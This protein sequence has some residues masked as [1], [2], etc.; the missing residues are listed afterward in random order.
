MKMR[1]LA[2]LCLIVGTTISSGRAQATRDAAP[3]DSFARAER[4]R[5]VDLKKISHKY[6]PCLRNEN[7]GVVEAAI[8]V[9]TRMKLYSPQTNLDELREEIM[10]LAA[11]GRNASIRY[12]AYI[13][14]MVIANPLWFSAEATREYPHD[15]EM[16]SAL[17]GR[18]ARVMLNPAERPIAH[19]DGF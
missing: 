7:D 16:F 10:K 2:V 19:A 11:Q 4:Y 9:V 12:R 13:A 6:L 1:T 18:L 3:A 15:P 5:S 8:G 17:S 14:S